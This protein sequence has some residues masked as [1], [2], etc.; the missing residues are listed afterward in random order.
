M[1]LALLTDLS[2][3][4][5]LILA[6]PNFQ[7]EFDVMNSLTMLDNP[8]FLADQKFGPGSGYLNYYLYNWRTA[9]VSGGFPDDRSGTS[10]VGLV[11]L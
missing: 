8:S 6:M 9:K 10:G 11:M 1:S 5:W 3:S 4:S 2:S 7:A